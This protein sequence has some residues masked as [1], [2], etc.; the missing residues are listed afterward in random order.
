MKSRS[1]KFYIKHM[2][3]LIPV[4]NGHITYD[5]YW[6]PK[7]LKGVIDRLDDLLNRCRKVF[8]FFF[9]QQVVKKSSA[10]GAVIEL[11]TLVTKH[12]RKSFPK[13][14]FHYCWVREESNDDNLHYH[15]ILLI[16]AKALPSFHWFFQFMQQLRKRFVKTSNVHFPTKPYYLLDSLKVKKGSLKTYF[17]FVYRASYLAKLNSKELIPVGVHRYGWSRFR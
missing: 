12:L 9:V 1:R 17:D 15:W 4:N 6:S 16:D 5:L 14:P 2:G 3:R 11:R 13:I 10:N 8:A 7:I